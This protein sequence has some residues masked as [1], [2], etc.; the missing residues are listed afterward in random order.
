MDRSGRELLG[1][2]GKVR[3]DDFLRLCENQHPK[4]GETLTQRLNTVRMNDGK[5]AVNR[6]V[7]YD[8]TFSHQIGFSCAW[9]VQMNGSLG[10]RSS[11]LVAMRELETLRQPCPAGGGHGDR[12]TGNV[13]AALFTHDTSAPSTAF[14]HSLCHL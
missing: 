11:G 14:A 8:F 3:A 6:R 9:L 4:S 10:S 12:S 7:F 1:L 2:S 5:E 13:A